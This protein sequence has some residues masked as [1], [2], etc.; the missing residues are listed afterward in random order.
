ME[1]SE[2]AE[3]R[4][5]CDLSLLEVA[6]V[7]DCCY[8]TWH[9]QESGRRRDPHFAALARAVPWLIHGDLPT[10]CPE[11]ERLATVPRRLAVHARCCNACWN[12]LQ[13]TAQTVYRNFQ[14][15]HPRIRLQGGTKL[16]PLQPWW[17][18]PVPQG[19]RVLLPCTLCNKPRL[20]RSNKSGVCIECQRECR[21][22]A[23]ALAKP[24]AHV[25]DYKKPLAPGPQRT[26]L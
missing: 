21:Q 26:Q 5:Q 25:W 14:R 13:A 17:H 12:T 1:P 10:W 23:A 6:R 24:T 4:R 18:R 20:S 2:F 16:R 11:G 22:R 8:L 7:L 3:I 9:H 19:R 15:S